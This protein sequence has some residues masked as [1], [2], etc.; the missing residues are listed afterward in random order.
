MKIQL[1]PGS[2]ILAMQQFSGGFGRLRLVLPEFCGS[3]LRHRYEQS[4]TSPVDMAENLPR[5]QMSGRKILSTNVG[6]S[7][8]APEIILGDP[9]SRLESRYDD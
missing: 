4:K 5:P 9:V 1:D 6:F 2:C 7:L 8:G 3:T